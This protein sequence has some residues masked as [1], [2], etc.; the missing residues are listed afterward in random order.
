MLIGV[1]SFAKLEKA[2]EVVILGKHLLISI[3]LIPCLPQCILYMLFEPLDWKSRITFRNYDSGC[4]YTGGKMNSNGILF[5]LFIELQTENVE[6][7]D[8]M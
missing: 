6:T 4:K 5:V 3:F 7:D 1:D 8:S 2:A